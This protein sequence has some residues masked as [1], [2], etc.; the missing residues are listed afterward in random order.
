MWRGEG[1]GVCVRRL[2]V[3]W[4]S[5]ENVIA[6]DLPL[7]PADTVQVRETAKLGG[8]IQWVQGQLLHREKS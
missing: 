1:G 8:V 7:L 4:T 2:H 3:R 6:T 5:G